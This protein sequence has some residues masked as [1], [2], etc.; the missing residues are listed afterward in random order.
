M[1]LLLTA[2]LCLCLSIAF[3]QRT[4]IHC[5]QLIDVKAG[6][7]QKEMSIIVEG[8]K[9]ADVQKGYVAAGAADKIIDLKNRTVMPGLIDM[10]VHL[11]SETNPNRYMETFTFNPA[12]YAFQSVQFAE[13]TLMIGFTTVRDL[14][15]SGV[16][17]SLRNA[18][19]RGTIKGPRIFTAGKS[20]ATT[21]GHADP[22]NG[23]KKELQGDPG[24]AAGVINGDDDARQAVRQRYKE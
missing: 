4:I 20:I 15:G 1:R 21:G 23:F 8:N 3:A 12:D 11:E 24:P 6:A 10:H 17:I 19:N 7:V 22:T 9:I 2:L 16:N 14:G 13:R 5:G 18:I